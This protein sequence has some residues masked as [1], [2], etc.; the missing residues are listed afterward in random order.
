MLWPDCYWTIVNKVGTKS[1]VI[2]RN[3]YKYSMSVQ[4]KTLGISRSNY[5]YEVKPCKD[6]TV[7]EDAVRAAFGENRSI[8]GSCKL[9]KVL[10]NK[11]KIFLWRKAEKFSKLMFQNETADTK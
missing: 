1:D 9:K 4:C 7:I 10:F 11:R 3:T 8:Y 5:Y 6:E 2:R